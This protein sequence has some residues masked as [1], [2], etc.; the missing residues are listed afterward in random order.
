MKAALLEAGVEEQRITVVL[1]PEEAPLRAL[2]LAHAGDLVV[3]TVG[4]G[5]FERLWQRIVSWQPD[6]AA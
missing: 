2:G 5:E 3:M 1:D 6:T 4:S